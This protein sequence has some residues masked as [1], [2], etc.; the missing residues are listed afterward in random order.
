MGRGARRGEVRGSQTGRRE[1]LSSGGDAP[2]EAGTGG[3]GAV[4]G[5]LRRG[6][7]GRARGT[8]EAAGRQRPVGRRGRWARCESVEAMMVVRVR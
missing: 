6:R 1:E 2:E 3:K 8:A 4:E 5:E 7:E